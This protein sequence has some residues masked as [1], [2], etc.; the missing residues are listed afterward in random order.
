MRKNYKLSYY[1]RITDILKSFPQTQF[2]LN[3]A[4]EHNFYDPDAPLRI[5][6]SEA[7]SRYRAYPYLLSI[8]EPEDISFCTVS[9]HTD[10][11]IKGAKVDAKVR[12]TIHTDYDGDAFVDSSK[13]GVNDAI[14]VIW[15]DESAALFNTKTTKDTYEDMR[16]TNKCSANSNTKKV[17]KKVTHFNYKNAKYQWNGR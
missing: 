4:K 1:Q 16:E 9:E 17:L 11:I 8:A 3:F 10:F 14:I 15:E 13:W 6:V 5:M 12:T 2:Y 7:Y